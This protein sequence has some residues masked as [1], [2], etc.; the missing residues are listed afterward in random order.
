[1]KK[2]AYL[3][4][5][6]VLLGVLSACSTP[7]EKAAD[8]IENAQ[9]FYK[10]GALQKAEIE[11]KNALQI[12]Q[13]L[14]DA[15]YGIA[16]IHERR[17]EWREAFS[18]LRKI[19]EL[20]PTHIDA[21]VKLAQF[22]LAAN[23]LD[24][25]LLDAKEILEMASDDARA[26]A[27]M[28]ALQFRLDNHD[29]AMLAVNNALQ[30]DP[31]NI[32][33]QLVLARIYIAQKK[34][35]QA[36]EVLDEAIKTNPENSSMYLMK[37]QAFG[38]T[39]NLRG[40]EAVHMVLIN[41]FPDNL[42]YQ[43]SLARLYIDD[44]DIDK[45]E[46]IFNKIIKLNPEK[47]EEKIRFVAFTRQYRSADQSINLLRE[48]IRQDGDESQFNFALGTLYEQS[49]KIGE[50]IAVYQAIIDADDLQS[51]ALEA[52][53]KIA[54]IDLRSGN[55]ERAI[56]LIGEVLAK[57]KYNENALLI[58]S[59]VKISDKQYDDAI[60]DLRTV[61]R[62]S[63]SSAK[64]LSLM[65]K[66]F[67]AK[68]S[69]ELALE[70]Y[71]K[72]YRGNSRVP[73]IANQLANYYLRNKKVSQ[74][75]EVLEESLARGNR[76][77]N[78]L[79]L[80]VQ[81]K[82]S[83]QEWDLAE[84]FARL[85]QDIRGQK[86]LSQQ[87]LGLVYLG[88]QRQDESIEAFK[89]AYELSPSSSKPIVTLVRIYVRSGKLKEARSFLNS[90]LSVHAK[91]IT[92][93]TLLGQ[94]SLYEKQPEQAEKFFL[95]SV[96]IKPEQVIGYRNLSRIY[97]LSKQPD[98]AEKIIR[99]GLNV[100]PGNPALGISLASIY[101]NQKDFNK[102][103]AI[104]EKL[105]EKSPKLIIARNNLASLLT[106]HRKD[107]AS[108]EKARSITVDFKDSRIPHFRDTYAWVLVNSELQLEEAIIILQGIVK[109]VGQ[110]PVFRYH[111]GRAYEKRGDHIKASEQ[112]ELAIE[113]SGPDTELS[114][115]S[116]HIL[117]QIN[118]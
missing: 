2:L 38:E 62:D 98:K 49:S 84:K 22:L 65:G 30:I 15:W 85:L 12:N 1:M 93:Y 11:F 41:K 60:V 32:E 43:H 20:S 83:L 82:L 76:S 111:L 54:L 44:K 61:L 28:A 90:V 63:P 101:E 8:Y 105:L 64:A 112:L 108:L 117:Q 4:V 34:F 50:A 48:Y 100:L 17:Q 27:L 109:E 75:N 74:A 36:H 66:A 68:G 56:L 45:A 95:K 107:K 104:Y 39:K 10:S 47:I 110:V 37:I 81:A 72:A 86:S 59:S 87:M 69:K 80:M 102:A 106:D 115:K 91:N 5:L 88:K 7:E 6:V 46:E 35:D 40:I 97:Q 23:Q 19:A 79:K 21:R 3:I 103:I 77:L 99:D 29:G 94:L 24:E 53:N 113:Y 51:D 13:N 92:A 26:H 31:L 71:V 14:V 58:R 70:N 55:R 16:Q 42:S 33:A 89:K 116:R 78:G 96:E 25:A 52:R 73:A 57:D 18:V 118:Q 9:D 114:N 67:E